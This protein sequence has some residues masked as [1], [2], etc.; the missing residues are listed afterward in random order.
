MLEEWETELTLDM[1]PEGMCRAIAEEIGTDNLLRLAS[2]VGGSTFY[3]PQKAS[4]LR[5]LRDQ[6][7]R[8]EFNGYNVDEL[9]RKYNVSQRWVQ[10][11]GQKATS[12]ATGRK[13]KEDQV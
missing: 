6:K 8:E 10:I 3:L 2:L 9:A 4:M 5:P 7:I 12:S 1:L 11:I 13:A